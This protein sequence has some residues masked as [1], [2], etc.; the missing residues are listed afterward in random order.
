MLKQ[1][2]ENTKQALEA[3]GTIAIIRGLP[4]SDIDPLI[5]ALYDGGIRMA[6]V[7]VNSPDAFGSIA[8]LCKKWKGKMYIGA[9]TVVNTGLAEKAIEAGAAFIVTPNYSPAVVQYC[10]D[11]DVLITPG[12]FTPSEMVS[13]MEQGCEYIK[14]FPA[15]SLGTAYIKAVLAPL[16]DAKILAVG[17]ISA[18][19]AGEYYSAGIFGTGVGGS[20]CKVPADGNWTSVTS[21]AE[22]LIAAFKNK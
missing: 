20:L 2:F 19:N 18:G 4:H 22:K 13:A 8:K 10:I 11:R 12:V 21:E 5:Q 15:G 3:T 16:N 14:L 6:E 7:T 1:A 9:G 17:G